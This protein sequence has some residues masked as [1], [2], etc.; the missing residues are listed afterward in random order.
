MISSVN[1][2]VTNLDSELLGGM[3]ESQLEAL[4]D[5]MLV[6][7]QQT[8]L[9]DLIERS[10]EGALTAAENVELDRLLDRIDQL[11]LLKARARLTLS[12]QHVEASTS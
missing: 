6:P 9:S 10:K 7:S 2:D 12:R 4:A 1:R 5:G 8:R 11:A 3:S